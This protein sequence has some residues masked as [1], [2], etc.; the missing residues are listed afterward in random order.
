MV[1]T[2]QEWPGSVPPSLPPHLPYSWPAQDP[3]FLARPAWVGCSLKEDEAGGHQVERWD[4][5]REQEK[6]E[7]LPGAGGHGVTWYLLLRTQH[8]GHR[9]PAQKDLRE[10]W[11]TLHWSDV[12]YNALY[13][14]A[15]KC[16]KINNST[17]MLRRTLE[18]R[19]HWLTN[20]SHNWQQGDYWHI[21]TSQPHPA[22]GFQGSQLL[23]SSNFL[24]DL[25]CFD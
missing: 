22:Q 11:T 20:C 9:R 8:A 18:H 15:L 14:S 10:N 24:F 1:Q 3:R 5:V 12:V 7:V 19:H 2:W 21:L 25:F 13:C 4:R 17:A 6:D 16:T 23:F